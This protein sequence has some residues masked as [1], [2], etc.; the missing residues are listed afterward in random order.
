MIIERIEPIA[1]R[2]PATRRPDAI[3]MPAAPADALHL[4]FCRVTTRSGIQGYGECLCYRPAMQRSLMAALRDAIAPHY[5][6][7]SIE[8]RETLSLETRRRLASFGRAGTVLNALAAID[9]ALWDIAGKAAGQSLATLLG[10]A[11]RTSI[12]VMASLDKY[13]HQ[14]RARRRVEQ[15]LATGVSAVKVHESDL[16]VIEEARSVV[17]PSI[18]FVADLNNA[19]ILGDIHREAARWRALNLLWLEDPVWPPEILLDCPAL[20]GVTIGLGADLGSAEQLALYGKA[21]PVGVVQPD[22]C[23]LGGLSEAAKALAAL[24]SLDVGVAPHTPFV[25]PAALA[26]LHLIA[27]LE[28]PGYF[29]TIEADD[30]MD[31][32]GIG[33]TRWQPSLELPTG[34]GLGFDPDP[35]YLQRY[36]MEQSG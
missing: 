33:L 35:A 8:R 22:V 3:P 6:G 14:A 16:A 25:G 17:A 20:S 1:L 10:G 31:P 36:A 5:L 30:H 27:A 2:I 32:Y 28:Q 12:P 21:A 15:A 34:P 9:I 23:M 24:K 11:R 4:V 29:A 7:Q 26:S 19:H 13:G 18:K